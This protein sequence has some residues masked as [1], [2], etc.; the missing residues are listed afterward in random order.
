[1]N[2]RHRDRTTRDRTTRDR[3]TQRPI[4][5]VASRTRAAA[6]ADR[7]AGKAGPA[8]RRPGEGIAGAGRR[9]DSRQRLAALAAALLVAGCGAKEPAGVPPEQVADYVHTVIAADRAVYADQVVHRLQDVE[10]IIQSDEKFEEKRAL[11]LPSQMLRMAAKKVAETSPF[12]YALISQWAINKA[13]MPRTPFENAGLAAV[14]KE[15]ARAHTSYETVQGRRYFMALYPDVAVS[16]ACVSCH[17]EHPESP[18][19]DFAVG[20]VMGGVVISIPLEAP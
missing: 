11:P 8:A 14:A 16:A 15:P 2:E 20:D 6:G 1:M 4:A 5:R 13:N 12:R 10:G 19:R 9:P 17:N 7:P 18:R 3:T